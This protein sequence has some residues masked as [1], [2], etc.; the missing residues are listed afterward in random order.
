MISWK[1]AA[2]KDDL[3]QV[4]KRLTKEISE[5][6]KQINRNSENIQ[7]LQTQYENLKDLPMAIVNLDK[8]MTQISQSFEMMNNRIDGIRESVDEIKK[9]NEHQNNRISLIGS[10]GNINWIDFVTSNFWKIIAAIASGSVIYRLFFYGGL[11]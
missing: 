9:E 8:T 1:H 11:Q 4:D 7:E 6:R 2:S 10:K 3:S 5:N